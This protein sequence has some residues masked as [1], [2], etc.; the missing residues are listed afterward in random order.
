M[1]LRCALC[2]NS[3]VYECLEVGLRQAADLARFDAYEGQEDPSAPT[4][5]RDQHFQVVVVER[6][7]VLVKRLL[8]SDVVL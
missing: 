3:R 8:G 5:D 2:G 7:H 6:E 1:A 4:V